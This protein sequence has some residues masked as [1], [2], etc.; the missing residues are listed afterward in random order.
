MEFCDARGVDLAKLAL[1]FCVQ[2]P[3]IA[4][5]VPGT[6]NPDNMAKQLQWLNEPVDHELIA[7]VMR[8]LEPTKNVLWRVGRKQNSV[9]WDAGL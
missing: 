4:T 1:Q 9:D 2:N 3:A 7:E 8:L 5:T 6:A